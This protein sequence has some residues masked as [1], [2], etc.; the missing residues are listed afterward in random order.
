MVLRLNVNFS[1]LL[2]L[3]KLL[4]VMFACYLNNKFCYLNL[5]LIASVLFGIQKHI[6]KPLMKSNQAKLVAGWSVAWSASRSPT[7]SVFVNVTLR[8]SHSFRVSC[9]SKQMSSRDLQSLWLMD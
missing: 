1:D 9:C 2:E 6:G 3:L 7:A 5:A 4:Q 8:T